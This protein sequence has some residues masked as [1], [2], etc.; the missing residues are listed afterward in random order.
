MTSMMK[1]N[2]TGLV[3]VYSA[4]EGLAVQASYDAYINNSRRILN[5]KETVAGVLWATTLIERP[6]LERVRD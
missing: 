6:Q 1:V 2:A 3:D 5:A 4:S